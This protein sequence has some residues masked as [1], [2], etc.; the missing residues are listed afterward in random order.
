MPSNYVPDRTDYPEEA[1][2]VLLCDEC[3]NPIVEGE[4]YFEIDTLFMKGQHINIC[5]NCMRSMKRTA[6][7]REE[8]DYD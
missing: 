1:V 3:Y 4:D 2:P 6:E 8:C 7:V 5:E